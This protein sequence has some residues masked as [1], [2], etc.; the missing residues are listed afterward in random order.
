MSL[1]VCNHQ[2]FNH[3]QRLGRH[4]IN[5]NKCHLYYFVRLSARIHE[6]SYDRNTEQF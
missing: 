1:T 2:N 4:F 3:L 6:L 5:I